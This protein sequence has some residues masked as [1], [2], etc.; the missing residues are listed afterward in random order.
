LAGLA[1]VTGDHMAEAVNYR[2]LDRN[3]WQ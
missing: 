2:T 3:Y 1:R